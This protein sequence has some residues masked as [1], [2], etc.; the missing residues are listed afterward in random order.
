MTA[1]NEDE[2]TYFDKV[3]KS[4]LHHGRREKRM[5][6]V[7][8]LGELRDPR[9]LDALKTIMTEDDPYLVSE[10]VE[11]I[12]KIGGPEAMEQ[13]Q[14]MMHHPSFMVRGEVALAMGEMDHPKRDE[15]LNQLLND[16]S[17]YV[18]N[19]AYLILNY[20]NVGLKR[21]DTQKRRFCCA[22]RCDQKR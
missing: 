17:P 21:K 16:I 11:A 3:L 8:I 14:I 20:S 22:K 12:G 9:A 19:C 10:A 13:L 18:A 2:D 7:Y 4:A 6:M 15:L 1:C 5:E